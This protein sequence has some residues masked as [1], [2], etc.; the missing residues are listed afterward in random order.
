LGGASTALLVLFEPD[1]YYCLRGLFC[2]KLTS[3]KTAPRDQIGPAD[4][5]IEAANAALH[6][7]ARISRAA[8]FR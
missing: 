8:P 1:I 2:G 3:P 5:A 7:T 6:K 4:M